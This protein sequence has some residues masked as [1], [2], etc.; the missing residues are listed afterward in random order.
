MPTL[1]YVRST[2]VVRPGSVIDPLQV[3]VSI[4]ILLA[5]AVILFVSVDAMS[6]PLAGWAHAQTLAT[7]APV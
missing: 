5:V 6:A 7:L 2:Q 3:L 4:A 1:A